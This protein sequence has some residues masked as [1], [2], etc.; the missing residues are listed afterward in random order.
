MLTRFAITARHPVLDGQEFGDAGAYEQLEGSAWFEVEPENPLNQP[1]VDLQLAPRNPAGHVECRADIWILKPVDPTR[2]NGSVL[3]NVVNPTGTALRFLELPGLPRPAE[4]RRPCRLDFGPDWKSGVIAVEPP[5]VG[6]EYP[7][8]VPAV[9]ED[10]NEVAGIRLPEVVV[11]LGTF[12]GWR[13]RTAA[14]GA[15][16]ALAGLAGTWLPLAPTASTATPGDARPSIEDRYRDRDDYVARCVQ[17]AQRLVEGRLLLDRDIARVAD[18]AHRM[19]DW[20]RA[21]R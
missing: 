16:W 14:M 19:Y 6:P 3:Y 2:G 7:V 17:A 12:T 10:G 13:F 18:R 5:R 8:L 15:T 21:R 9:D 1:V 11:P 20:T 4:H